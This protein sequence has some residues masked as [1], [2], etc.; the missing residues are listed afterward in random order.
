M[1]N[2]AE[3]S[4]F[5]ALTRGWCGR[6]ERSSHEVRLRAIRAGATNDQADE[7]VSKLTDEH[8]IDDQRYADAFASG[9]FRIKNWGRLKI[10][11]ALR[12]QQIASSII[13]NALQNAIEESDYR[14]TLE[15]QARKKASGYDLTHPAVRQKITQYLY[16]RGFEPDLIRAV[17]EDLS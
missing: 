11:Q 3:F 4:D 6:R 13:E 17:L 1:L 12:M 16:G 7:A 9:H 10:I 2:D 15:Q 5:L 8:F 14:D